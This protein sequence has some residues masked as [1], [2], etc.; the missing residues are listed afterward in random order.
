MYARIQKKEIEFHCLN[1]HGFRKG[2]N[3]MRETIS[4]EGFAVGVESLEKWHGS[5]ISVQ[6]QYIP[7]DILNMDLRVLFYSTQP[8]RVFMFLY[9]SLRVEI[10]PLFCPQAASYF[11]SYRY[12]YCQLVVIASYCYCS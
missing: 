2:C 1:L 4:G 6:K 12:I 8:N 5:Y 3:A 11:Y 9:K 10:M 7:K